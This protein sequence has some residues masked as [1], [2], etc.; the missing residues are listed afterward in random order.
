MQTRK[1]IRLHASPTGVFLAGTKPRPTFTEAEMEAAKREAHH[2]GADEAARLLERQML[3]QRGELIHLQAQTFTALV[4]QHAV[5]VQQVHEVV[6][7]L[8]LEAIARVLAGTPIDRETVIRIVTDLLG[9]VAPGREQVEVQLAPGDLNLISGY[10]EN[11]R[12]KYPAIVFRADAELRP[13]DCKVRS[14]FGVIDGRLATKLR[15]LESFF[16]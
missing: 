6:P 8:V 11:F 5:L 13:G 7:E 9:E 1:P 2:R 14:R 4:E 15:A 3:E 10:E 12:E 16:K